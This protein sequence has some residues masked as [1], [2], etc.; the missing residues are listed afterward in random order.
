MGLDLTLR[1]KP[2][3]TCGH[4]HEAF[5]ASYTYNVAPMWYF[6]YPDDEGMVSIEGMTGEQALVK[7]LEFSKQMTKNKGEMVKLNPPNEWGSYDGFMEFI[8][9]LI[10]ACIDS[11]NAIWEAWR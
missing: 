2:C 7:L 3:E 10:R 8:K 11:P 5:S 9:K 4:E 6:F 1:T